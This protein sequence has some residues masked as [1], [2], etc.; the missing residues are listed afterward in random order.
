V[1][2]RSA[3]KLGSLCEVWK[4]A[5]FAQVNSVRPSGLTSSTV[6]REASLL[7]SVQ[8][9]FLDEDGHVITCRRLGLSIMSDKLIRWT[10]GAAISKSSLR[11]LI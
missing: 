2:S 1:L 6:F 11:E 4:A 8:Q 5:A 9:N 10:N 3:V 7:P